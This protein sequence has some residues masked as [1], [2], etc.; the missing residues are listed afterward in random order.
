MALHQQRR[1]GREKIC[2]ELMISRNTCIGACASANSW[3]EAIRLLDQMESEGPRPDVISY[4]TA[5]WR[6][7]KVKVLYMSDIFCNSLKLGKTL[8]EGKHDELIR[9]CLGVWVAFVSCGC[10]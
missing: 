5:A 9:H 8:K 2:G 10:F 7:V 4:N 6:C 3:V 1:V